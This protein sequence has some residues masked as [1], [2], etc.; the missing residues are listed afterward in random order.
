M[1]SLLPIIVLAI[2]QGITEFLPIS[3]SGH[4]VLTWEVFERN[5]VA[6]RAGTA[7]ERL[8][9]DVAVH[10]GSLGAVILYFWRDVGRVAGGGLR[11]LTGRITDDG[12][13]FLY[14]VVATVPLVVAGLLVNTYFGSAWRSVEVV[15]WASLG[16]GLLLWFADRTGMTISKMEH[17]TFG[18][19]VV[20]GLAQVLALIPG[21][22]RSGIA[23]TAARAL[24]FERSDA[25][26]IS[27]LLAIPAILGAS[28][29]FGYDIYKSG[30]VALQ[31]DALLAALLA[32]AAALLAIAGMMAWLRR[33]TFTPFAVYRILL[34]G[35]LLYLIYVEGMALKLQ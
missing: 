26:T 3:S 11:L 30:N 22:S 19:A 27:M 20:I 15:A 25:A 5:G 1:A 29:L 31:T 23:M 6:S 10:L 16:F 14:L 28:A 9:L 8:T 18:Q 17:T 33:A 4:L 13:L 21:T 7:D 2:V 24:G 34:G 12:R 35:L 32:L